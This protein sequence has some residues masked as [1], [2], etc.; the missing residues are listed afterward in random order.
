MF[1][2]KGFPIVGT[3]RGA[4]A[5]LP[6]HWERYPCFD[7]DVLTFWHRRRRQNV[8]FLRGDHGEAPC[9]EGKRYVWPDRR[10]PRPAAARGA[11]PPRRGAQV[12]VRVRSWTSRRRPGR[13]PPA[14][15]S[16]LGFTHFW[17]RSRKG[18]WIVQRK[19]AKN[20]FGRGPKRQKRTAQYLPEPCPLH[21]CSMVRGR[22]PA[23]FARQLHLPRAAAAGH[24][25]HDAIKT[26]I[27]TTRQKTPC[28]T[29]KACGE[30]LF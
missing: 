3:A 22:R 30:D 11:G 1:P 29:A 28:V 9:A 24:S 10:Y 17:A 13:S 27:R 20:R 21:R 23:S 12:R 8:S 25:K 7:R 5:S 26:S 14:V 4:A 15:A 2:I 16:T 6:G 19:T 18:H